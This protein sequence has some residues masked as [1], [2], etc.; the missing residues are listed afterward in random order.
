MDGKRYTIAA[1]GYTLIELLV[2]MLLMSIFAT[3]STPYFVQWLRQYRLRSAVT[4][5][6]NHIRAARLLSIYKGVK[7]QVQLADTGHGNY[8]QVVEDPGGK[9]M[10]VSSIGR[11]VM[12]SRFGDVQ[13]QKVPSSGRVTFFPR[14][15][16]NNATILLENTAGTQGKIIVNNFGRVRIEYLE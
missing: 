5:L 9:D 1:H 7:H 15:T 3:L 8:Y 14:G 12:E 2:V 10:I 16:S 6:T 4:V 13:L 11:V